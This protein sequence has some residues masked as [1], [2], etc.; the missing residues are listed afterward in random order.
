[1]AKFTAA[2]LEV[3]EILWREGE[4]SATQ[5]EEHLARPITNSSIRSILTILLDKGHL[6]R[7]KVGKAFLYKAKTRPESAFTT[8]YRRLVDA[9][10]RGSTEAFLAHLIERENL[11]EAELLNLK[12]LGERNPE[13][14]GKNK[15]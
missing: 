11:S 2:E 13:G 5:I 14:K 15:S 4:L 9:F 10:F 3:I 12:R 8:A 7:R 6:S 1:M